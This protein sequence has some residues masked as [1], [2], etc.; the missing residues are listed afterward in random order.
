MA[1]YFNLRNGNHGSLVKWYGVG[2][3]SQILDSVY[4]QLNNLTIDYNST[5]NQYD[6]IFEESGSIETQLSQFYSDFNGYYLD[7]Y[8]PSSINYTGN[9]VI[10]PEYIKVISL[11]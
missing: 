8:F 7:N 4:S 10:I 5:F 1:I 3:V 6:Q 11:S 2:N 9:D